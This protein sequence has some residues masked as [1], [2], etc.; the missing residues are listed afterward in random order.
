M[1]AFPR[2]LAGFVGFL[3]VAGVFFQSDSAADSNQPCLTSFFT[4][5]LHFTGEGMRRW[6][7]E[8]GGFMEITKIPYDQLNCKKCHVRSCD[9]CH[10]KKKRAKLVFSPKKARDINTCLPC[11]GREGLTFRFDGEQNKLDVHLAAGMVCADCHWRYDI[12]GDGRFRPSMRHPK[13]V[14]ASCQCCHVEQQKES[15]EFD[16]DTVSHR[17][18]GGKLACAACHVRTTMACYNCHFDRFL[19]TGTKKGNFVPMKDWLLL[20]NYQGK[21]T[22]GSAMTLVYKNKKF[23]AYVPYFTHSVSSEGRSCNE[24][25]MNKAVAKMEK[26]EKVPVVDFKKGKIV[27]WKGV[28]PVVQG[29]LQWAFLNKT[30]EGWQPVP[31]QEEPQVQFAAYGSP[32]NTEQLANMA[33][34]VSPEEFE[35]KAKEEGC[36]K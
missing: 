33:Q 29:K 15:P 14:R 32:L 11:H 8:D 34:K 12:H 27:P 22:S 6:Y 17:V 4:K 28:V 2:C 10:A 9:Q 26:G 20:I 24:C 31:S 19:K 25:H 1:K 36:S 18:H 13:G 35:Q 7:E 16:P 5:S 21:V 3:L 23:I 30:K